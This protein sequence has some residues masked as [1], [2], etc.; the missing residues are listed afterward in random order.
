MNNRS[1]VVEDPPVSSEHGPG[2][3][4]IMLLNPFQFFVKCFMLKYSSTRVSKSIIYILCAHWGHY[5]R[6]HKICTK[7]ILKRQKS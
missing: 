3:V 2:D 6:N 7:K 5:Q 1:I 4:P